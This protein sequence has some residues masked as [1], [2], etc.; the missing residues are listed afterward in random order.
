QGTQETQSKNKPERTACQKAERPTTRRRHKHTQKQN[1]N[2]NPETKK[3]STRQERNR[4]THATKTPKL[5]S[6]SPAPF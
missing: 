6:E 3:Q 1:Q 2:K 4:K 5:P